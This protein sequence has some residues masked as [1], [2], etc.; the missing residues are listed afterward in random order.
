MSRICH[1]HVSR[2]RPAMHTP[3]VPPGRLGRRLGST[4]PDSNW[5]P[6]GEFQ[7]RRIVFGMTREPAVSRT[8]D[9]YLLASACDLPLTADA[10]GHDACDQDTRHSAS[11]DAHERA[12]ARCGLQ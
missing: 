2:L 4:L 12:H 7:N 5:Q 6:R 8:T 11:K 3:G 1:W 10:L 9:V